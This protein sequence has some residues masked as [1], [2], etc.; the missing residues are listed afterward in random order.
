MT[1]LADADSPA[2]APAAAPAAPTVGIAVAATFTAE[3]LETPLAFMLDAAGLAGRI[4]F[5]PY[6]Q[7]FQA[8]LTP[9]SVLARDDAGIG[10]V[11]LRLE[12]FARDAEPGADAVALVA[13][14]AG[15]LAGAFHRFRQRA[16]QP[17]LVFVLRAS[18][19]VE[20]ALAAAIAARSAELAAALEALPDTAVFD[21]AA[22][23]ALCAAPRHD[24]VAD[25]LARIPYTD[26]WFAALAI[27]VARQVHMRQVAAHKVLVLDCDNT[28]WRGVVGEDGVGGICLDPGFLAVQDFAIAAQARG[29]L[30]CLASKNAEADVMRVFDERPDM[31]LARRHVVAHRIDWAPKPANLRALARE[32]NLG[33]DAFVFLDDNPVECGLMQETLPEVV[34]LQL[35]SPEEAA[36]LLAN[37]WTFDKLSVTQ[38][39]QRRTEMYRQNAERERL[40][41][42]ASDI[43]AFL[44]SL[45]LK[46]SASAPE[47]GDWPRL[48]QLTLRTNQFNFTTR[49]RSEPEM[50]A[51]A[52]DATVQA[53]R[54]SDRFGDY[55]LVGLVVAI[56]AGDAVEV[57]TLLLS[58]RVLGR[59]VEHAMLAG[60]G[61]LAQAHGKALVRLRLVRTTRNE[62]ALAFADAV[63]GAYRRETADGVVWEVPA[64]VAV[65]IVHRAGEDAPEVVAARKADAAKAP[66]AA[67]P[68]LR[69]R[70]ARYARLATELATGP[71]VMQALRGATRVVRASADAPPRTATERALVGLWEEL[72]GV[73][74]LGLDDDFFA[75]GGTSLLAARMIA[76]LA[77]RRGVALP[78][79]TIVEAPTIR[80]F[81]QRA[82][83]GAAAASDS[84]VTLRRAGERRLFLV[85]DG[86]G[87]TL[88]YRNLA[89]RLPAAMSVYGIQ[90]A[91]RA[92]IPL[93]HLSIEAMAASYVRTVRAEQPEGPYLLGGMCAGGLIAFEMARQ[94][95][96]GGAVVERVLMMD[97][98]TPQ[99]ERRGVESA[100]RSAR[101]R[102]A[103]AAARAGRGALAGSFAAAGVV[104]RKVAGRVA[105]EFRKRRLQSDDDRRIA[106]L[107]RVLAGGGE[108]PASEP[109][110]D[111]RAIYNHAEHA[112]RPPP[113]AV[114][115]VLLRATA[116]SGDDIPYREVFLDPVLGWTGIA[117]D[118]VV[119]DVEG[120]HAS[121]LQEPQAA[122]LARAILPHLAKPAMRAAA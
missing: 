17:L 66:Q 62:P 26:D 40:E 14:V 61:R 110:L 35:R 22:V 103:V 96:A 4:A 67:A 82:D 101:L 27:V 2:L 9:G 12:D 73:S 118:L 69:G 112:Y 28:L 29:V 47:E 20:P 72:L 31:R 115:A 55:G 58:C 3:G 70:S 21:D 120:G 43:G 30:V 76:E 34:T 80:R 98:A 119:V 75:L 94:L 1:I 78:L 106:T 81:A 33:L 117:R 44:A 56:D 24:P 8:L 11:L 91:R 42:S 50:R 53:V 111:F 83:Q 95:Q 114:G 39:D 122:A 90:P 87:E 10:V 100:Q 57:D 19:A 46:I 36:S 86:D 37:L 51:L 108:W 107:R 15:E 116:G 41:A 74:G 68:S 52:G 65:A 23:D 109:S 64:D 48:S 63:V 7:V 93:A 16:P 38:E 49:R 45:D 79:T 85:H 25:Q 92:R 6:H 32:L 97:S 105:W 54:V 121:M 13:R 60:L 71:A 104:A 88:L 89:N 102:E 18:P 59:G 77:H 5:A 84:L 113:S 99:A